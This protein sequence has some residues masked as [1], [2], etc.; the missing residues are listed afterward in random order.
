MGKSSARN[1]RRSAGEGSVYR[2]GDR[3]RGAVTWTEPDGARRR[4]IVS[5]ATATEARDKLDALRRELRLGTLAPAGPTMTIGEYLATWIERHRSRVRPSTWRTAESYVRVYLIPTLGRIALARLTSADVERALASFVEHGRPDRTGRAV[6]PITAYHVRAVLRRALSDAQRD[7]LV[8]RNAAADARPP[9]LPQRPITYLSAADVRRLLEVTRDDD[10]GPLWA[11][12]AT[13]GL[14]RGELLALRWDDVSGGM[15]SVRRS[16]SRNRAGGWSAGDPKSSRSRRTLPLPAVAVE[17][18]ERQRRRQ[19]AQRR[20]AGTAW[21]G[22]DELVFTDAIGRPLLP[23]YVSH[24]FPRAR[25]AAGV[26]PVTLHGLRH[27]AATVLLAQGLPLA[28]ISELLG[29]SGISVTAAHYAAVV[30]ALRR[31]AA[32]AMDLALR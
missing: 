17:A 25:Q 4:R 26:P 32:D 14:R 19:E 28:V 6:A 2:N 3:W 12:A 13:T 20:A 27:S 30:P 11:L 1:R 18:L 10:L 31:E 8:G 5:A 16:V 22:R 9:Y 23:E 21:Q 7:G 15:L 24:A 29:H